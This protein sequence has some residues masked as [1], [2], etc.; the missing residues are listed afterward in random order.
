M[1]WSIGMSVVEVLGCSYSAWRDPQQVRDRE[2]AVREG[3]GR[4]GRGHDAAV[5]GVLERFGGL[6]FA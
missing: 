1:S 3:A 6:D 5:C 2:A 4:N